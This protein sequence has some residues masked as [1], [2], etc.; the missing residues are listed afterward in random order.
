MHYA[1][2]LYLKGIL[3][4]PRTETTKYPQGFDVDAVLRTIES[5]AAS[6]ASTAARVAEVHV[7]PRE[8]GVDYGDHPP[9][10]PVKWANEAYCGDRVAWDLYQLVCKYFLA[11]ISPDCNV[12]ECEVG[13]ELAGVP[14]V[15][16]SSRKVPGEFTWCDIL[17]D[18]VKDHGAV[19]LSGLAEGAR[20]AVVGADLAREETKPPAYLTE[21]DL[22][23]LMEEH[24][25]GTD[26]SM[27]QH[28]SNVLKRG[29]VQ[30]DKRSRQLVPSSMGLALAHAY[31]LVDPSLVR[32]TVR[33]Q[34]ENACARVAK[35]E[36]KKR[37][38]VSEALS[39]FEKKFDHFCERVNQVPAMLSVAFT[40]ERGKDETTF[41]L[42]HG[43]VQQWDAAV[44][45]TAAISLKDLLKERGTT[46]LSKSPDTSA[47]LK[48]GSVVC[49]HG[50]KGAPELNG[51]EGTCKQLEGGRWH[52]SLRSGEMKAL[53][54]EN[55]MEVGCP[56]SSDLTPGTAVRIHSLK[57]A[58]ELNGQEGVCNN[59]DAASGRWQVKFSSGEL[60]ALKPENLQVA[61]KRKSMVEEFSPQKQPRVITAEETRL[62]L[63][64]RLFFWCDW[65]G[66]G[67]LKSNEMLKFARFTGFEGP[68]HVWAKAFPKI[69]A[70]CGADAEKG[71]PEATLLALLDDQSEKGFY[72]TNAEIQEF[73]NS[74]P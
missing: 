24:G 33:S 63:K 36:R 60:K 35:G 59:F 4:Y 8:D 2:K 40:R 49:I 29:Y 20:C 28:I 9:I 47:G 51:Q 41:D 61:P 7:A 6:W 12:D 1:E 57:G 27:A 3:S 62:G 69:C 23:G 22:L 71:I 15:S 72:C 58:P 11:T 39:I 30:L 55:L 34:I 21:S 19:D 26:A 16:R 68:D 17:G 31:T 53:K 44:R 32:P 67:F 43:A 73:L 10:M 66:D 52:V 37:D 13:L 65:D 50:L 42:P 56:S 74:P 45:A 18:E 38:V 64:R 46:D 48:P 25:I 70:Q 54:A 14:L 5:P